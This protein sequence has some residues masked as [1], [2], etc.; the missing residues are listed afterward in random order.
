MLAG[1]GDGQTHGDLG[2]AAVV[3]AELDLLADGEASLVLLV[4]SVSV[5]GSGGVPL[6]AAGQLAGDPLGGLVS[7]V[8]AVGAIVGG[9][10]HD[11]VALDQA[12][13]EVDALSDLV[14]I[15]VQGG[16]G[17][18]C[19]VLA[20]LALEVEHHQDHTVV[21]AQVQGIVVIA[22]LL[23]EGLAGSHQL[24]QSGGEGD[25]GLVE[26]GLVP[27]EDTAGHGD[28]HALLGVGHVAG[29]QLGLVP[30][31]QV[32]IVGDA[33][34][35]DEGLAVLGVVV[36]PVPVDLAD[37]LSDAACELGGHGVLPAG[38]CSEGGVDGDG[39]V[40]SRE[41]LDGLLVSVVTGLAAPPAHGQGDGVGRQT[42]HGSC[43]G[44]SSGGSGGRTSVA[45]AAAGGQQAGSTHSARDLQKVTTRNCLAH[46]RSPPM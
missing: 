25:A 39:A 9:Q 7:G 24:V 8:V 27:V 46:F 43:G 33:V 15:V 19:P 13:D 18:V 3:I 6:K 4:Q 28:R 22:Q 31:G 35:V 44:R 42:G 5:L 23:L 14:G 38:P 20:V 21:C 11:D 45:G 1:L 41:S 30:L 26:G 2:E 17:G 10:A 12:L 29:S 36:Q 16:G 37:I 32:Q 40:L 34:Q